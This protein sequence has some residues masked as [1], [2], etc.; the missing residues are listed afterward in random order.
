LE[1]ARAEAVQLE[2]TT[3]DRHSELAETRLYAEHLRDE[4]V[5]LKAEAARVAELEA[6][7]QEGREA[8]FKIEQTADDRLRQLEAARQRITHLERGEVHEV[9][10]DTARMQEELA[11]AQAS[12]RDLADRLAAAEARAKAQEVEVV[13]AIAE[14]DEGSDTAPLHQRIRELEQAHEEAYARW[15]EERRELNEQWEAHLRAELAQ[16][17]EETAHLREQVE[18]LQGLATQTGS[19]DQQEAVARHQQLADARRKMEKLREQ[20][21]ELETRA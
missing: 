13:Q 18:A 5:Q 7:L 1:E 2:L 20:V 6:E 15:S 14:P 10:A 12:C 21:H 4:I 9:E 17:R 8:V 11:I 16:A 3:S 19:P